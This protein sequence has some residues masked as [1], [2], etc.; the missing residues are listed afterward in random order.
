MCIG[1]PPLH[2]TCLHLDDGLRAIVAMP[3]RSGA[4][5]RHFFLRRIKTLCTYDI[6]EIEVSHRALSRHLSPSPAL[7]K[8]FHEKIQASGD[9]AGLHDVAWVSNPYSPYAPGEREGD[10][11]PP[12]AAEH[13]GA[14]DGLG[15]GSG[16]F[17]G[18]GGDGTKAPR[19][20][21]PAVISRRTRRV[22]RD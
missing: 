18:E 2:A 9:A 12:E 15:G 5:T 14:G 22:A 11:A 21:V 1:S 20:R 13:S 17:S 4:E 10:Q 3:A 19:L 7:G 6:Q 8:C 16:L